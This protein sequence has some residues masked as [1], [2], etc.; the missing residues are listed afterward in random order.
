[1]P[2]A[3]QRPASAATS[4]VTEDTGDHPP[5]ADLAGSP[6]EPVTVYPK[7]VYGRGQNQTTNRSIFANE[8]ATGPAVS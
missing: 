5:R 7:G 8:A 3:S 4:A 2:G 1:M 6:S